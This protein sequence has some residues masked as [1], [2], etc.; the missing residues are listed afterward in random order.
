MSDRT[1]DW[2]V[3]PCDE[4]RWKWVH[5]YI[6]HPRGSWFFEVYA[7]LLGDARVCTKSLIN[8]VDMQGRPITSCQIKNSTSLKA[9][10]MKVGK[11]K[12]HHVS[13]LCTLETREWLRKN[14]M[15]GQ[16]S[17]GTCAHNIY[18]KGYKVSSHSVGPACTSSMQL[19]IREWN[20]VLL[21]KWRI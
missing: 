20:C 18:L 13:Y 19:C 21:A 3:L 12:D 5:S 1:M 7:I 9:W 10:L 17:D 6:H 15:G 16:E 2:I 14:I 8:F 4:R 11:L